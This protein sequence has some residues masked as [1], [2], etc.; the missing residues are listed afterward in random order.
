MKAYKCEIKRTGRTGGT[1]Y[2]R[3]GQKRRDIWKFQCTERRICSIHRRWTN[4]RKVW[5]ARVVPQWPRK[6][7]KQSFVLTIS[8][9]CQQNRKTFV[10][11]SVITGYQLLSTDALFYLQSSKTFMRAISLNLPEKFNLKPSQLVLL[12]NFCIV[13]RKV[14]DI[15]KE[16]SEASWETFRD[17]IVCFRWCSTFQ[18]I[19]KYNNPN[20][21]DICA[22]CTPW[23]KWRLLKNSEINQNEISI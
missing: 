15:K 22:W 23:K 6:D 9:S 8:E 12:V 14:V 20:P 16:F 5:K 13:V 10:G 21:W 4:E 11:I 1:K 2:F 18:I 19:Q 3:N 17:K 7:T